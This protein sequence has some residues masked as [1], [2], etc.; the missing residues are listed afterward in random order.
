M[1]LMYKKGE[2]LYTRIG[3]F[4]GLSIIS[5]VSAYSLFKFISEFDESSIGKWWTSTFLWIGFFEKSI[6][7]GHI[8]SILVLLALVALSFFVTFKWQ[9][10][11]DF[12]IET[13]A[14]LKKVSWPSKPEWRGSSTAVI[15]TVILMAIFLVIVDLIFNGIII[16]I[17]PGPRMISP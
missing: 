6:Y 11:S 12:L 10:P 3:A 14:E 9:R 2:G 13:E 5:I 7:Y 16:W 4:V 17:N 8:V 15:V 1:Q